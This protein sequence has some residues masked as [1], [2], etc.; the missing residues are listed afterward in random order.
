MPVVI[1]KFVVVNVVLPLVVSA[2]GRKIR[3]K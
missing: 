2:V 1:L 3:G